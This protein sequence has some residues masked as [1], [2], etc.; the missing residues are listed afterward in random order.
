MF[1]ALLAGK[2]LKKAMANPALMK[3]AAGIAGAVAQTAVAGAT[4]AAAP[5]AA[6]EKKCCPCP[7]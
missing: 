1:P 7:K 4:P 5:A 6:P 3:K 2:L